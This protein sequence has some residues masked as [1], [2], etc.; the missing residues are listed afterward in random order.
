MNRLFQAT[1]FALTLSLALTSCGSGKDLSIETAD[2]APIISETEVTTTTASAPLTVFANGKSEYKIVRSG[3]INGIEQQLFLQFYQQMDARSGCKFSYMEDTIAFGKTPDPTKKELL[4]GDTNRE[5]SIVLREKLNEIGG[6]RFAVLVSENKIAV[7]GTDAYQTYLGLDYL[8]T[9]FIR[10]DESGAPVM[11]VAPGF[12]YI[13]ESSESTDRFDLKELKESGRGFCFAMA[14]RVFRVPS[15]EGCVVM[16]GG[17]TDGQYAYIAQINKATPI[18]T[19]I[20]FKFD[21]STMELVKNSAVLSTGHTNDITYDSKNQRLVISSGLDSWRGTTFL[22]PN[23]LEVTGHVV[24]PI[25]NRGIAYLPSTDQYIIAS[26]YTYYRTDADFNPIS[27]FYCGNPQ[28]TT[29]GLTCDEKYIYDAR[30]NTIGGNHCL[31]VHDME[32]NYMGSGRLVGITYEPENIFICN[33]EYYLGC[34]N[35]NSVYHLELIPENW[36]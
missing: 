3:K 4:L 6:N 18:E 36:W 9:T 27:S 7:V 23:T 34:N 29:Q 35:S 2:T 31:V 24:A 1:L 26:G 14:E 11:S 28:Y 21:L 20:I 32:G 25:G 33:G 30:Y 17:G 12:E 5:E 16:Q 19:A 13:S 10:T 15:L 8:M 22:D